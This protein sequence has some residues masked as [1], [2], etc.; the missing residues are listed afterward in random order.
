L[1]ASRLAIA[2]TLLLGSGLVLVPGADAV[3]PPA[4]ARP[5]VQD[6]AALR[7]RLAASGNEAR[8]LVNEQLM[9][10]TLR[11]DAVGATTAITGQLLLDAG[12]RVVADSSSVTVELA[13]LKTDSDRRDNYVRRRTLE[14]EQYPRAVLVPREL[15]GL[16]W[17]LPASGR[18]DF[19]LL[20]DLTL[21][22]VT[23]PTT[24]KVTATF[25]GSRVAGTAR[26]DFKFADF[27]LTIPRVPAVLSVKDSI[28]LEYDFVF[29]R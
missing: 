29:E 12:G 18:H 13:T 6:T 26:T 1:K 22:G 5:L 9:G 24:W 15:R 3:L 27:N 25:T 19:Q 11:N 7:L 23:A 17:P 10:R 4:P 16:R 8:Y 28:R 21:H 14:V 20:G 2:A